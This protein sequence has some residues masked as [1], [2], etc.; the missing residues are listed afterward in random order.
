MHIAYKILL[1]YDISPPKRAKAPP[2]PSLEGIN[3]GL[4]TANHQ[5][6]TKEGCQESR[7]KY[8]L[9]FSLVWGLKFNRGQR[10][11]KRVK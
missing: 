1:K 11:A 2:P 6:K 10:I 9:H 7:H 4:L 3:C 8:G 5:L